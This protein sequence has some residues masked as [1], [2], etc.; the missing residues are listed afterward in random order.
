M[1]HPV[2][3]RLEGVFGILD[4][5]GQGPPARIAPLAQ[6]LIATPFP[7]VSPVHIPA[8]IL[9][10]WPTGLLPTMGFGRIRNQEDYAC[11]RRSLD[12]S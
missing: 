4:G 1:A 12:V 7:P 9:Y 3:S 5:R 10:S 6:I 11:A 8:S 2:V